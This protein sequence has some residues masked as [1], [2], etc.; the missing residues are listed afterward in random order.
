MRELSRMR[1]LKA[2]EAELNGWE[3]TGRATSG[4]WAGVA[5]Q[6]TTLEAALQFQSAVNRVSARGRAVRRA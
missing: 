1:A 2:L 4:P 5:T 3:E 6:S